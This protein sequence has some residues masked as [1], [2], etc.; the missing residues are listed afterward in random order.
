MPTR[1]AHGKAGT[2][3]AVPPIAPRSAELTCQEVCGWVVGVYCGLVCEYTFFVICSVILVLTGL[4]GLACM[5]ISF[6]TC[7]T[8]C[9]YVQSWACG[10]VCA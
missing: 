8:T 4:P 6:A 3:A 5:L 1:V 2:F 9:N 10:T 7:Y